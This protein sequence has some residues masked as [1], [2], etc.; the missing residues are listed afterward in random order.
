MRRCLVGL[1][2]LALLGVAQAQANGPRPP[3]NFGP[4]YGEQTVR[5]IL[6]EDPMATDAKLQVPQNLVVGFGNQPRGFGA[7][8][9]LPTLMAGLALTAAFVSFGFW[10]V[11]KNR[12]VAAVA[13]LVSLG[14]FSVSALQADIARPPQPQP[15]NTALQ[16]PANV[17]WPAKMRF[18]V[19]PVNS[20]AVKLIV[21]KGF[22]AKIEAQPEAKPDPKPEK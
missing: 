15:K 12:T 19:V 18:E 13:L 8:D 14:V 10:L 22:A 17:K 9:K 2:A 20:D 1:S 11:K 3:P 5:V 7:A 21:P 6:E 4:K 16:L